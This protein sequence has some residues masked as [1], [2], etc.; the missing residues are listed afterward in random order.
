[1]RYGIRPTRFAK[2]GNVR[3]FAVSED[4]GLGPS[5]SLETRFATDLVRSDLPF[6]E[7]LAS[8][9]YRWLFGKD[10]LTLY[11]SLVTRY[12]PGL[13]EQQARRF[14]D[15]EQDLGA[16]LNNRVELSLENVFPPLWIGRLHLYGAIV[17]RED[18]LDRGLS[19]LG[20]SGT[21]GSL[22]GAQN[23]DSVALRG[24][25]SGQFVG[26]NLFRINA[27]YRTRPFSLFTVHCGAVLFY[28]GGAAWGRPSPGRAASPFRYRQSV[29]LG[30]RALVPQLDRESFRLDFGIPIDPSTAGGI[31]TW[32]SFSFGQAF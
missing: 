7:L 19:R 30:F 6:F 12:Q 11:G 1:L 25:L 14:P 9:R 28:D 32:F 8:G 10:M 26:R 27:E 18:D 22:S 5:L 13:A 21:S 15:I 23:N 29:G 3:T 20:G 2:L 17:L 16:W 31:D 4:Y 24:Y